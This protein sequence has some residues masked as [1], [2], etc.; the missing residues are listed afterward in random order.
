[1]TSD[2]EDEASTPEAVPAADPLAPHPD[3]ALEYDEIEVD[4]IDPLKNTPFKFHFFMAVNEHYLSIPDFAQ[5]FFNDNREQFG[6]GCGPA[7]VTRRHA[8]RSAADAWVRVHGI[9]ARKNNDIYWW[10]PQKI[11]AATI[12]EQ[13]SVP[14]KES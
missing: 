10:P 8:S 5:Q 2:F 9:A 1:M 6:P 11:E 13:P 7:A 4:A 12:N 14:D 3:E